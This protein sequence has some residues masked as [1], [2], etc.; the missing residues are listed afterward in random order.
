MVHRS[1]GWIDV[2]Y[3]SPDGRFRLSR[4]NKGTIFVLIRDQP[5]RERLLEAIQRGAGDDEVAAAVAALQQEPGDGAVAAPAKSPLAQGV[6]RLRWSQQAADA[7]PLQKALAGSVRNEQV[8]VDGRLDNVVSFAPSVTLRAMAAC[9][10]LSDT[11]TGVN[12]DGVQLELGP[13]KYASG[14]CV[15]CTF[16]TVYRVPLGSVQ[17][18]QTDG[19]GYIDWLYLDEE[20]RVTRGN[21]GSLFVHTRE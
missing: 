2:T 6:W 1:Q 21:K 5:P 8:I 17:R 7:N 13:W 11:R 9:R 18:Q 12:I 4:G 15:V 3:L 10:P 14:S 16:V 19:G 20:L